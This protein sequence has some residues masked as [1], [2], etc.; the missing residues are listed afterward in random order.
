MAVSFAD[1]TKEACE[2]ATCTLPTHPPMISK[3]RARYN[4]QDCWSSL[5][6]PMM[7][8]TN[9]PMWGMRDPDRVEFSIIH[10]T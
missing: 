9:R 2:Q 5:P 4:H 10:I 6:W 3:F 1:V 7:V 8:G